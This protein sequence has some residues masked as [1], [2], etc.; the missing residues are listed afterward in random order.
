V[1]YLLE[2]D[3]HF[4]EALDAPVNVLQGF[5]KVPWDAA[6]GGARSLVRPDRALLNLGRTAV[7]VVDR[8]RVP[9]REVEALRKWGDT[10]EK[11]RL[12]QGLNVDVYSRNQELQ[13]FLT[14]VSGQRA[15]GRVMGVIASAAIPPIPFASW[16]L[17]VGGTVATAEAL[18]L[19]KSPR[20]V[21]WH[22]KTT[23]ERLGCDRDEVVRFLANEWYTPREFVYTA[24]Y[25]AAI[26]KVPGVS[27][28]PVPLLAEAG[29]LAEARTR[30]Q[31]LEL[32][33]VLHR[34][35]PISAL[36]RVGPVL[37]VRLDEPRVPLLLFPYDYLDLNPGQTQVF[38][39][40]RT[41]SDA[42]AEV[43]CA[44]DVDPAAAT[45]LHRLG[46][47]VRSQVLLE[48]EFAPPGPV[49]R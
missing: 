22:T 48:S 42:W 29:T 49:P 24:E 37:A 2:K 20:D 23:L 47:R 35:R 34:R 39:E 19:D 44:G 36:F 10:A 43:W 1:L 18:L 5:A 3:R 14:R 46:I 13:E 32:Y 26:G 12:A 31:Q 41:A 16:T 4:A 38:R 6:K 30:F 11:R 25:L 28:E 45:E 27:T 21:A 8:T 7:K 33:A 17:T 9:E 40:L 15:L